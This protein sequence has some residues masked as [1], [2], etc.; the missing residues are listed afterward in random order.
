MGDI[1]GVSVGDLYIGAVVPGLVLV[2]R[3]PQ[4]DIPRAR[5][6]LRRLLVDRLTCE[7]F[8]EGERR[9]LQRRLEA[10]LAGVWAGRCGRSETS[11]W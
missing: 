3:L 10:V 8:E 2:V 1:M 9:G 11:A 6:I 7:A 5:Q 4:E